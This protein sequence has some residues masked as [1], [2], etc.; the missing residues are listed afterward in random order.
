MKCPLYSTLHINQMNH[1]DSWLFNHSLY[2]LGFVP[3]TKCVESIYCYGHF[4]SQARFTRQK[5]SE[6]GCRVGTS[7]TSDSSSNGEE[8]ETQTHCASSTE[9]IDY[10]T[11]PTTLKAIRA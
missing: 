10:R 7:P 6:P 1:L 8:K 2:L 4:L 5:T 9:E 3:N 11:E